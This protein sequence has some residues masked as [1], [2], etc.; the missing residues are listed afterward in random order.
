MSVTRKLF[1]YSKMKMW[2]AIRLSGGTSAV[3]PE[4]LALH[5]L[6][7]KILVAD[8]GSGFA[9]AAPLTRAGGAVI[10]MLQLTPPI[11]HNSL[12]PVEIDWAAEATDS[13]ID[14]SSEQVSSESAK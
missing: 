6:K 5:L 12:S 14:C 4:N 2:Q 10:G 11:S 13:V 3:A 9:A 7:N 1:A 8:G